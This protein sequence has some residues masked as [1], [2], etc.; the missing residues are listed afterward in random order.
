MSGLRGNSG[1]SSLHLF[2]QDCNL[3]EYEPLLLE[4]GACVAPVLAL[5]PR[6]AKSYA[7]SAVN[8]ISRTRVFIQCALVY[9]VASAIGLAGVNRAGL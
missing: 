1:V 6:T 7:K 5:V 8:G 9:G 2:L 4:E 3:L